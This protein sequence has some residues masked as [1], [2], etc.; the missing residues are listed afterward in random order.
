L[1]HLIKHLVDVIKGIIKDY[2]GFYMRIL[3]IHTLEK[4]NYFM[5]DITQQ[6]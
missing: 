6:E 2:L 4:M 3:I 1:N 5:A